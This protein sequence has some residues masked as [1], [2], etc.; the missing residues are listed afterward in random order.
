MWDQRLLHE[1]ESRSLP[2]IGFGGQLRMYGYVARFPDVKPIYR[3]ISV[4]DNPAWR[5]PMRSPLSMVGASWSIL[6]RVAWRGEVT[7]LGSSVWVRSRA[8]FLVYA[9]RYLIRKYWLRDTKLVL[10]RSV[11]LENRSQESQWLSKSIIQKIPGWSDKR[12]GL[13]Y[14][15]LD[16]QQLIST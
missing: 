1:T 4:R 9:P 8:P 11:K 6:L 7:A 10:K 15:K 5:R 3:V 12:Y 14:C 13:L 16:S 2:S